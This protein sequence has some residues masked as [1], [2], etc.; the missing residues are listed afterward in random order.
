MRKKSTKLL[1]LINN[2]DPKRGGAQRILKLLLEVQPAQVFSKEIDL[3]DVDRRS[4]LFNFWVCRLIFVFI[5]E[6]PDLII[7]HSRC[8]LPLVP[9]FK[10]FCDVIFY[11]HAQYRTYP[12]L[13]RVFKCNKYI[14]VS[15]A[16]KDYLKRAGIQEHKVVVVENPYLGDDDQFLCRF[17]KSG[18]RLASIGSIEPW[19]GFFECASALSRFEEDKGIPVSWR[20]I[21]EGSYSEDL[22]NMF[23]ALNKCGRYCL[24]GY[25]DSPFHSITDC[26]IVLIPSLEE[27]FG[28]VALEAVFN[29]RLIVYSDIPAL[30]GILQA[31][32]MAFSYVVG[33][34]GSFNN[35]LLCA[36]ESMNLVYDRSL[37]AR[38]KTWVL[39]EYGKEQFSSRFLEI[40]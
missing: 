1:H 3:A 28:L 13:F 14:A 36:I 4:F 32:E 30:R 22:N 11:C 24:V 5:R 2:Q 37:A 39:K 16:T 26:E 8:F 12:F 29:H 6:R 35:A 34:Q 20:I 25:K 27:G 31:D 10:L 21:G 15:S 17:V 19:K 7:I 18:V 33:D 23:K 38:R 9:F 40:L